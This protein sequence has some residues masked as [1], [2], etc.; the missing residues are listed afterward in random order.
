MGKIGLYQT[1]SQKIGDFDLTSGRK[2]VHPKKGAS[3]W[4]VV[5]FL[6]KSGPTSSF[7]LEMGKSGKKL[8]IIPNA[9]Y[10]SAPLRLVVF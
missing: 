5:F 4:V 6:G 9:Q 7:Q 10:G 1:I 2:K 8:Q 3:L